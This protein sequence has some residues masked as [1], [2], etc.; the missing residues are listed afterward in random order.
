M[1]KNNA[2]F[3]D[4]ETSDRNKIGQIINYCFILTDSDFNII[5]KLSGLVKIGRLQLPD[6]YAILANKTDVLEHQKIANDSEAV[7]M[8]KIE[9][10]L[11]SCKLKSGG[12]IKLIGFNS[13]KFDLPYLR[14]SFIRNGLSP[15]LAG[16]L[17]YAD[18]YQLA[19]K[20]AITQKD[21]PRNPKEVKEL[22]IEPKESN[23]SN[24]VESESNKKPSKFSLSLE[25]LAKGFNLLQG[26]QLHESEA[27]V[28]LTIE[29]AKVFKKKYGQ[30]ILDFEAYQIDH[31][32]LSKRGLVINK[33]T[34]S[35]KL[36]SETLFSSKPYALLD[37]DARSALWVDLT[38]YEKGKGRDS[39]EWCN[40]SYGQFFSDA[41]ILTDP[42]LIELS[43]KA[44]KEFAKLNLKNFFTKSDCDI[45]MDIYRI[46]FDQL[47]KL[48]QAIWENKDIDFEMKDTKTVFVRY[49][50]NK[51]EW[52]GDHDQKVKKMIKDYALNRY[53]G[54]MKLNK[55]E[56]DELH[57]TFNKML[58]NLEEES[59][60]V[61]SS[62]KLLLDSL[63]TF[64]FQSDIY[65][66]A[67]SELESIPIEQAA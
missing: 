15:Y 21:F 57:Q 45:E 60:K 54:K 38:D 36:N 22:V 32:K 43:N 3:Y 67:G 12:Q 48:N 35:T 66:C 40:T 47:A 14:T 31:K 33:E 20:L 41:Q 34:P 23:E 13:S 62:D 46:D 63:K 24:N 2:V 8:K 1:S 55:G 7:A 58:I 16:G 27:D 59:K 17:K 49:K 9:Q 56:K 65:Q 44:L 61:P 19:Q 42:K 11:S 29:L 37:F 26:S 52:G 5:E 10:F 28:I 50:L 64:Y 51:Y 53:G 4:L 39:I 25:T 30:S 18:M 6:P